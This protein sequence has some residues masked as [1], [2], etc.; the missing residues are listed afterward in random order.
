MAKETVKAKD[1]GWENLA[2]AFIADFDHGDFTKG[3]LEIIGE[4]IYCTIS[5]CMSGN[6][7]DTQDIDVILEF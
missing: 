7:L 1:Y 5:N 4:N 2:K 3:Q 6:K